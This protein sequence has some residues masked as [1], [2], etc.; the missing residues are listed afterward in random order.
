VTNEEKYERERKDTGKTMD[1]L[2]DRLKSED[3][4]TSQ[5]AIA[6]LSMI[7]WYVSCVIKPLVDIELEF[8]KMNIL[9]KENRENK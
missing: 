8:N 2:Y 9:G 7:W 6:Y 3:K 1:T 5:Q 4:R